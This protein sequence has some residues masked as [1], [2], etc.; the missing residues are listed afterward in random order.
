MFD[1]IVSV[2]IP[3][4][5]GSSLAYQFKKI[6]GKEQVLDEYND[7]PVN[8]LSICNIDPNRYIIEPIKSISPYKVVH[9]HFRPHKFSNLNNAFWMT[10]LRHPID[11]IISIYYFWK[12]YERHRFDSP[13]FQYFKDA[14]LSIQRFAMLPKIRYLYSRSYFGG[15]DMRRFDF[16]GDYTKYEDELTRLGNYLDIKFDMKV[17][18]NITN[19]IFEDSSNFNEERDTNTLKENNKLSEI[20]KD[21]IQFY[22]KYRYK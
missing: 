22:E 11:N 17:R 21:D 14:N 9:G 6:Y 5:A 13:L 16:I 20:L 1:K 7:D 3:K 8:L 18:V 4:A 12:A 15:F 10:F 19:N 2:H